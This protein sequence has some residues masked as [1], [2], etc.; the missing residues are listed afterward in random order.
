MDYYR[1]SGAAMRISAL[2]APNQNATGGSTMADDD[3]TPDGP[4]RLETKKE[5]TK[6]L[7]KAWVSR[8]R[9]HRS[10]YMRKWSDDHKEHRRE[11]HQNRNKINTDKRTR[12]WKL[13]Y[14]KNK[15]LR[16][17]YCKQW[18]AA[19]KQKKLISSRKWWGLPEPT[20]PEP[21]HC[22]CCGNSDS[23]ALCL[24]HCHETKQFRGWLCNRCNRAIGQLGDNEE[25]LKMALRYLRRSKRK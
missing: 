5:K 9:E 19:N 14:E 8:N 22:E 3:N 2:T 15:E 16:A 1:I 20:R 21:D 24:D 13:W 11:Y 23:R 6:R 10:A 12:N 7:H 4:S 18:L 25:A 17:E